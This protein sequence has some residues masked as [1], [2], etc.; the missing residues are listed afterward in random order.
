MR[1]LGPRSSVRA[2][3]S[4]VQSLEVQVEVPLYVM[5]ICPGQA[6]AMQ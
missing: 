6:A 5:A 1:L 3:L 2:A 4:D